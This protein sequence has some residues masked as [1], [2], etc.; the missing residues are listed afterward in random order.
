MHNGCLKKVNQSPFKKGLEDIHA[1]YTKPA[2]G[3]ARPK[4]LAMSEAI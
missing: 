3:G 2:Q 1:I 4:V